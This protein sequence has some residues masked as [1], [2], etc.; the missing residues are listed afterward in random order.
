MALKLSIFAVQKDNP[1]VSSCLNHFK[2]ASADIAESVSLVI[3]RY[4]LGIV[5]YSAILTVH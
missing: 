2:V 4:I 1:L 3:R 5:A